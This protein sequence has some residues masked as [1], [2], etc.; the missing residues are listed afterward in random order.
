MKLF[1]SIAASLLLL[2]THAVHAQ[3]E[4]VEYRFTG[5]IE[6][7][8]PTL[9]FTSPVTLIDELQVEVGDPVTGRLRFPV[10]NRLRNSFIGKSTRYGVNKME[11]N[12]IML[13]VDVNGH[14][15]S[16]WNRVYAYRFNNSNF[17]YSRGGRHVEYSVPLTEEIADVLLFVIHPTTGAHSPTGTLLD[18]LESPFRDTQIEVSLNFTDLSRQVIHRGFPE[19]LDLEDFDLAKGFIK[20]PGISQDGRSYRDGLMFNIDSLERVDSTESLKR[21][22]SEGPASQETLAGEELVL[23]VE[24]QGDEALE[25]QWSMNG[26]TLLGENEQTLIIP[27]AQATHSGTYR[28]EVTDPQGLSETALARVQINSPTH[29][30]LP[31]ELERWNRDV[32][33]EETGDSSDNRGFDY[34]LWAF[35]E[36]GYKGHA[37][38]FPR[39]RHFT[40]A[41][42]PDVQYRL[43]PFNEKNSLWMTSHGT[44]SG[45]V[46]PSK[47][48][49]LVEPSNFSKLAIASASAHGGGKGRVVLHFT[50]GTESRG[51]NM[52]AS[53]A[54]APLER[55]DP[56]AIEG[57]GRTGRNGVED[58]IY[59][60]AY[61]LGFG[62]YETL[63]DLSAEGLDTKTLASLEFSKAANALSTGIFAVSGQAATHTPVE[64][65]I[66]SN[67]SWP[68]DGNDYT[69]EVSDSVSGPW[70][71]YQEVPKL[72]DERF[73]VPLDLKA[74]SSFYR[75]VK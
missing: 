64:L 10:P 24:T 49:R 37:D 14:T 33:Y 30:L 28:V 25:F 58:E 68:A 20:R 45:V 46:A 47:V 56:I 61:T 34:A 26:R 63:I 27:N 11:K 18:G 55:P 74:Q 67:V 57:L 40:S 65:S 53:D 6:A 72:A 21:M 51:F 32:I 36:S 44:S 70:T 4:N 3:I 12:H 35:F 13:E 1:Q 7:S 42:S 31:L 60:S 62:L 16:P 22:I 66:G 9:P 75:L 54:Q 17:E 50:D 8:N 59:D 38:G 52:A 69:L 5:T 43:Q 39:S 41:T 71:P 19:S 15:L 73:S 2:A 23:H 48:L 29:R